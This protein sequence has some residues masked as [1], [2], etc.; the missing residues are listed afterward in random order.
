[1]V[2]AINRT[3]FLCMLL[4]ILLVASWAS[5]FRGGWQKGVSTGTSATLSLL[6]T[7]PTSHSDNQHTVAISLFGFDI[8]LQ[9]R[10]A[11]EQLKLLNN[12]KVTHV[13]VLGNITESSVSAINSSDGSDNRSLSSPVLLRFE[14]SVSPF[15]LVQRKGEIAIGFLKTTSLTDSEDRVHFIACIKAFVDGLLS[16]KSSLTSSSPRLFL[17]VDGNDS[18]VAALNAEVQAVIKNGLNLKLL[19]V[20]VPSMYILYVY[21]VYA[22][23]IGYLSRLLPVP[24]L[25][26]Q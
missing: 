16:R 8:S 22:Y 6:T 5:L 17:I 4:S 15:D 12:P 14:D 1:M 13:E 21:T 3:T 11:K 18:D 19:E 24:H 20:T 7:N 26:C 10:A 23:L 9:G 2:Y 25:P